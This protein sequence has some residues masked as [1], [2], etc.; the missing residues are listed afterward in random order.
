MKTEYQ[1][2]LD[3][4]VEMYI[5][6]ALEEEGKEIPLSDEETDRRWDMFEELIESGDPEVLRGLIGILTEKVG[7]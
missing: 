5:L 7:G 4:V 2:K 1:E 6:F 3:K